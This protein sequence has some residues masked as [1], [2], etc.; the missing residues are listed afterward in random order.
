MRVELDLDPGVVIARVD[1]GAIAQA[2]WNLL[3]NARKY[4]LAGKA[5]VL[6]QRGGRIAVRDF[7]TGVP[8]KEREAVFAKFTRGTDQRDGSVPGLGLGLH[9]ARAIALAHG[10]GLVCRAPGDGGAGSEFVL[11]LPLAEAAR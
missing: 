8:E 3:D 9:L 7:G 1:R 2:L 10:G 11:T 4:A 6:T 5:V